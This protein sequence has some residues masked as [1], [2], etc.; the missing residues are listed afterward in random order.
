MPEADVSIKEKSY[1]TD[2]PQQNELFFLKGSNNYDWGMKNRLARIFNPESGKTVMLA[3]DHGY[4]QGPTTGL[5]R[6][7]I[8]ILPLAPSADALM[9]TR[10]ILRSIIPAST[11]KGV[12]MRASGGPSILKELSNENIAVDMEDALRMN[13]SAVAVQVFIGGE[14][15]TQSVHNLT[16]LVDAGMKVGMPV[17]GV[18]AVGKDM[19]RDAKYMGLASRICAEL[20]AAFVKTY[21]VPE[22][23]D[24]VTAACP[25]P[26]V[27][28]GGKK[29][30]ELE[31]LT[32]AAN[33]IQAGALGV[34]MGRN[35]FQSDA[36]VAM[37]QAVRKVVHEGMKP[38]IAF[39]YFESLKN[40]KK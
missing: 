24:T 32:M 23:F 8:S 37:L 15:E 33:A 26:I 38:R 2:I 9:L 1:F 30:P 27:I 21:Y 39:E 5:E 16:R 25:V 22:D 11:A 28:A 3:F 12:V 34:D 36:P 31:A 29:L 7:D 40:E 13:V 19:A 4:F 17:L 35:I 10:G 6:V 18:T 14:F 20:G